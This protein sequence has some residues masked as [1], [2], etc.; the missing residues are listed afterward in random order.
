VWGSERIMNHNVDRTM[1]MMIMMMRR[2][3]MMMTM[4]LMMLW[5]MRW[6]MIMSRG[7]KMMMSRGGG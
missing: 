1:M 3:G 5:K 2:S 4:M 7:R 6:R